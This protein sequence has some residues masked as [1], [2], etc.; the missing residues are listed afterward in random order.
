MH[1]EMG[2]MCPRMMSLFSGGK[3]WAKHMTH[4]V[5]TAQATNIPEQGQKNSIGKFQSQDD[6]DSV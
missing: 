2:V 1:S 6:D 5:A 4:S 3:L